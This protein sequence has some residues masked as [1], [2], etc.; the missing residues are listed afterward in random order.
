MGKFYLTKSKAKEV[1]KKGQRV[2]EAK[3]GTGRKVF[4][5]KNT[6]K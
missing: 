6:K 5:L 2:V 1:R 4:K 3:Q